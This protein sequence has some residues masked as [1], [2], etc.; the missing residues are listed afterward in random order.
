MTLSPSED[1]RRF[2]RSLE[3]GR[4]YRTT[5]LGNQYPISAQAMGRLSSAQFTM[6]VRPT[7]YS[8]SWLDMGV[9]RP[10]A[11]PH[12]QQ[13]PIFGAD[14]PHYQALEEEILKNGV[15]RPVLISN[16]KENMMIPS[17][18]ETWPNR[19]PAHPLIDG[20]HRAYFAI[21]HGLE[22]PVSVLKKQH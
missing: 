15:I 4:S 12:E 11:A 10:R 18:G 22:I 17:H 20:H 21:K 14:D 16:Q 2:N 6:M 8:S 3:T 5:M 1:Q 7:D 13:R 19:T 9:P